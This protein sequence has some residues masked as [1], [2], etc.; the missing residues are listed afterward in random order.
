MNDDKLAEKELALCSVWA[1]EMRPIILDTDVKTHLGYFNIAV[2]AITEAKDPLQDA[3]DH[4]NKDSC[5]HVSANLRRPF[6]QFVIR[7]ALVVLAAKARDEQ[8]A[9]AFLAV[10]EKLEAF[11]SPKDFE[12]ELLGTIASNGG[13]FVASALRPVLMPLQERV[14]ELHA[15]MGRASRYYNVETSG[16]ATTYHAIVDK[17]RD[18]GQALDNFIDI[19]YSGLMTDLLD[20]ISEVKDAAFDP[21]RK[22]VT[23][24]SQ[25]LV[26]VQLRQVFIDSDRSNAFDVR[27]T[28][29]RNLL[30]TISSFIGCLTDGKLLHPS[31]LQQNIKP[32]FGWMASL[33]EST[34]ELC[35]LTPACKQLMMSFRSTVQNL[36]TAF[37]VSEVT[38]G[39]KNISS[40]LALEMH[41]KSRHNLAEMTLIKARVCAPADI[42]DVCSLLTS[43]EELC[44]GTFF[45]IETIHCNNTL[46]QYI[47]L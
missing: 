8:I 16:S 34:A 46:S 26:V 19:A 31:E 44:M 27:M 7:R 25:F 29:R 6:G 37:V 20:L 11:K 23:E 36:A 9:K 2:N 32:N 4:L 15:A 13:A 5:G 38:A 33:S 18:L 35:I 3:T 41:N 12:A 17:F 28:Q 30:D 14:E 42:N 24:T 22:K 47:Y 40:G 39:M 21:L 1:E 10:L 43:F 45:K